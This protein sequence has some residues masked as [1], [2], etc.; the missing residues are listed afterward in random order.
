M[1]GMADQ[2]GTP[3]YKVVEISNVHDQEIE[4]VLNRLAAEGYRF[5][6]IHFVT[7]PGPRRPSTALRF[8]SLAPGGPRPPRGAQRGEGAYGPQS[9]PRLPG[10]DGFPVF[11]SAE[12]DRGLPVP[13]LP[14]PGRRPLPRLHRPAGRPSHRGGTRVLRLRRPPGG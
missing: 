1:P 9:R 6:S 13:S 2:P 11:P 3:P 8:S 10:A 14:R 5:E 12:P 7:Q 4:A